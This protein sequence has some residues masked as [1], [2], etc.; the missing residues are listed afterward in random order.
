MVKNPI[1][2]YEKKIMHYTK[3]VHITHESHNIS[4]EDHNKLESP[5]IVFCRSSCKYIIV[6]E[7]K[8]T[9]QFVGLHLPN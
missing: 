1:G 7:R 8:F 2:P 9:V 4:N 3:F 6:V 5:N